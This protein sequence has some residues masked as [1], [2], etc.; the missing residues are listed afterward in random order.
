MQKAFTIEKTQA[1]P[2]GVCFVQDGIHVSA[3]FEKTIHH[4]VQEEVGILLYDKKNKQGVRV[5]FPEENRIGAVY[6]ML[7]KGYQERDCSYLFYQGDRVFQDVR[8]REIEN[9]YRYG[10]VKKELPRCKVPDENYDWE[11]DRPLRLP[12]EDVILYALH[13]RGFTRHRS[14][15]VVCRGTFAGLL[16][17]IPYLKEL[18]ITSLLL[19][20]CYE[21]DEIMVQ[22]PA[23][24]P[25]TME[26]AA[27]SYMKELPSK[28][29]EKEPA[30]KI[31][32]W[33]YQKGLYYCPKSGYSYSRDAVTEYKD[34]VKRMHH[35]GIEVLMQFYF[36]PEISS[37]EMLDI[38]RYWVLE[39]HI[40]GFHVMGVNVP[41]ELIDRDPLLADTKI[42]TEQ[43]HSGEDFSEAGERHIGWMNDGFLYD[44][45]KFL[46]GDEQMVNSFLCHIRNNS[47][48]T[49]VV[50]YMA[51]WDGFRLADMVS[52]NNKHNVAN[53]ED[54]LDG[55][56][57][58]CSWNCGVEGNSRKKTILELRM[59]Q[60]K[61]ALTMLFLSQGVPLLYSGDEFGNSQEGNNNPYCQ[62]NPVT[63]IKWNHKESS[64][65]LLAY[66]KGL[67]KLRKR[68]PIL[69]C[70]EPLMGI[71][72][73]SCGYPDISFHGKEAWRANTL[74]ACRSVGILYCDADGNRDD[75]L[76]YVGVNMHWESQCLGLPKPPKGKTWT[77]ISSTFLKD[78]SVLTAEEETSQTT[79]VPARTIEI[80]TV[81]DYPEKET[82]V[83]RGEKIKKV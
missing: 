62:D 29:E 75:A 56:D 54:N 17:K 63:W 70:G 43:Q 26:E 44:M 14:S 32:Y 10:T 8:C 74:P 35:N 21:F 53:G 23:S 9:P 30:I 34:M 41:I 4:G 11:G 48:H 65:E 81:K 6:S 20:P 72:S 64:K 69:H 61:N 77:M 31:N 82:V 78:D 24:Q 79:T 16:E 66:T 83:S 59:R 45:R 27:S 73:R 25:L 3:V 80:Y 47:A 68:H 76:I 33:G 57:Y 7:L 18:G 13:V 71:D 39:Y 55:I 42:L 38:L 46:K 12:F 15:E 40:D 52:Y 60:M 49:G 51:K 19:M 67:I 2:L 36:P 37:V 50:N 58:N 28:D 5:P 1:Y 22:E